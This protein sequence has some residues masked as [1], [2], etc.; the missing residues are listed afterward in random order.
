VSHYYHFVD[1]KTKFQVSI[2]AT[3]SCSNFI[4]SVNFYDY[5]STFSFHQLCGTDPI[6]LGVLQMVP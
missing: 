4:K 5:V 1:T 6:N 3:C 2:I